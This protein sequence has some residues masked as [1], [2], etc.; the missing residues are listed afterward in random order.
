M[1]L[2]MKLPPLTPL[3][4]LTYRA[5]DQKDAREEYWKNRE[6]YELRGQALKCACILH[7]HNPEFID[8]EVLET[9]RGFE[10]HLKG[11]MP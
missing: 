8:R 1:V 10:K 2:A 4:P 11:E 3:P 6:I 9:A 5:H 7:Q